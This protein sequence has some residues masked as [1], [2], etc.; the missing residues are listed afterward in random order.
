MRVFHEALLLRPEVI[1]IEE[2]RNPTQALAALSI[3]GT[4][5]LAITTIHAASISEALT[6]FTQL[7]SAAGQPRAGE[8]LSKVLLGVTNQKLL[9][10]AQDK[11]HTATAFEILP[12][13]G[14]LAASIRTGNEQNHCFALTNEHGQHEAITYERDLARLVREGQISKETAYNFTA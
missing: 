12:N 5:H 6:R 8:E 2:I 7:V 11:R 1:A 9:P 14:R 4:G 10:N 3:A 13:S